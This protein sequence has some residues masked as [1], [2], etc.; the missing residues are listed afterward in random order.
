M[1]NTAMRFFSC[2]FSCVFFL[3]L[4][5]TSVSAQGEKA[6]VL[7]EGAQDFY[8]GE[9]LEAPRLG[10]VDL[11]MET[12][13]FSVLRVFDGH[14]FAVDLVLD[15]AG[16]TIYV[17]AEDTVYK[18][19][20]ATGSVLA[21]QA[22][23]GAR[24]LLL[25]EDRLF[26]TRGDYDPMTFGSV[27]FDEYLVA[28]NA[29]DLT[30]NAGWQSDGIAGPNWASEGLCLSGDAVYVGVNNAFAYGE[31]VGV[32]GRVDLF[33]GDYTEMDLGPE[34]LNP[35]HVFAA[36][37][38]AVVSV[39]A[40]Q[41]DG[42]SLS[43]CESDGAVLTAAVADVTAGCA[44]AAWH[45]GG[46]FYQVYGEAGFR[47]AD[48]ATLDALEG[49]SGNGG[50]VYAM[51]SLSEDRFLLGTTDFATTGILEM[52]DL[53]SGFQWDLPVGVAPGRIVV[54]GSVTSSVPAVISGPKELV[55]T[56]DLMG[57]TQALGQGL[58]LQQWSDGTVTKKFQLA[59]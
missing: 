22:L 50:A 54:A 24:Q 21:E 6:Y 18:L 30:W 34:G 46:V 23:D 47:K 53:S 59:D 25:H 28:L 9:V 11:S 5:V 40:R 44:A 45:D 16:E 36:G 32:I 19:D 51:A 3:A 41:Y 20:A 10:V 58:L 27:E 31:E 55:A 57:R 37:D 13:E 1:P 48:G 42:T 49:W 8:S 14:S 15:G 29:E 52:W 2:C 12:P 39:N 43:R 35:V 33:T 26:V 17:A 4:S 56:Y 7:C 38:G